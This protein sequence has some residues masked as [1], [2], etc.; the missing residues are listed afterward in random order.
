MLIDEGGW[1]K[2]ISV[3]WL[4]GVVVKAEECEMTVLCGW[5]RERET[6]AGYLLG[7]IAESGGQGHQP[8]TSGLIRPGAAAKTSKDRE[9]RS[10]G[11]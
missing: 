5:R 10:D 4:S 11:Q 6:G 7:E 9:G 8:S 2:W 1:E 3:L